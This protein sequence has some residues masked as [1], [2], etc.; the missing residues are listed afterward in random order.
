[1]IA[2]I[3]FG[4]RDRIQ[5]RISRIV[6]AS[7]RLPWLKNEEGEPVGYRYSGL[8][9]ILNLL[10]AGNTSAHHKVD[11]LAE[12]VATLDDAA[13][14]QFNM[15]NSQRK[16]I[17]EQV[18]DHERRLEAIET[19]SPPSGEEENYLTTNSQWRRGWMRGWSDGWDAGYDSG[20]KSNMPPRR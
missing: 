2:K 6:L 19:P 14:D 18:Q 1:M 15:A 20:Q 13:S 10:R 16:A 7:V 9:V 17:H 5:E 3:V 12:R 8:A 11:G 4:A